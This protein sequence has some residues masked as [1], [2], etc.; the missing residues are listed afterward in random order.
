[1]LL[2]MDEVFELKNRNQWMR[3]RIVGILR[4][5]VK[6]ILGDSM[7]R[8]VLVILNIGYNLAIVLYIE[9]AFPHMNSI[10]R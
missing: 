2:L 4:Q 1:M 10:Y 6:V 3:R 5:I 8:L 7:N 9:V